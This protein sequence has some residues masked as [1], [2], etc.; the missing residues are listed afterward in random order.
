MM[1]IEDEELPQHYKD[2]NSP[3][4]G[5]QFAGMEGDPPPRWIMCILVI[6]MAI[7]CIPSTVLGMLYIQK[8]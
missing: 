4:K 6:C 5:Q 8:M 2:P 1:I 3:C 7:F